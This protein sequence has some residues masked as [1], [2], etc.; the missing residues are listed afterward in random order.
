[1]DRMVAAIAASVVDTLEFRDVVPVIGSIVR[2]DIS[3]AIR[4]AL[5]Q[6]IEAGHFPL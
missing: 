5:I 3:E 4:R 2:A 6:Q 1:M